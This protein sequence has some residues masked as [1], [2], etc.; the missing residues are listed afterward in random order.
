MKSLTDTPTISRLYEFTAK[1]PPKAKKRVKVYSSSRGIHG[2]NPS[3]KDEK[4]LKKAL[5]SASGIPE[6]PLD[7]AIFLGIK[8]FISPAKSTT[9]KRL[10]LISSEQYRPAKRPDLDNYLKLAKD[11]ATGILWID[12][13]L[14][15]EYLPGTGKYYT[16][17]EQKIEFQILTD[18]V[19]MHKLYIKLLKE[20]IT[21]LERNYRTILDYFSS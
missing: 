14:I 11:A 21:R 17:E 15:V 8:F 3:Q 4:I 10:E 1:T 13:N 2:V 9:K 20:E 19:N 7:G 12:D 16:L 6:E 5:L 18:G